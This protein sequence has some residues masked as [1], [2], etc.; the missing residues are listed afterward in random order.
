M[1]LGRTGRGAPVHRDFGLFCLLHNLWNSELEG[2]KCL[3]IGFSHQLLS[4]LIRFLWQ[5]SFLITKI[6]IFQDFSF[7]SGR[8]RPEKTPKH[9]PGGLVREARCVRGSDP[10]PRKP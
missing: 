2:L 6:L 5:K 10:G 8:H 9:R 1:V 3:L 7:F 4:L